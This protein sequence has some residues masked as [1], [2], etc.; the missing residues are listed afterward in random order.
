MSL[1]FTL[2]PTVAC[3]LCPW[4]AKFHCNPW[5]GGD[6]ACESSAAKICCVPSETTAGPTTTWPLTPFTCYLTSSTQGETEPLN[7]DPS[8]PQDLIKRAE[9]ELN[10][11]PSSTYEHKHTAHAHWP[12]H[13]T[14]TLSQDAYKSPPSLSIHP[15]LEE[16]IGA[17]SHVKGYRVCV[18]C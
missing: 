10:L 1:V 2:R 4:A 7:T 15:L 16:R 18:V 8:R 9:P 11:P 5:E 17:K 6:R 14:Q 12:T 13:H 3:I